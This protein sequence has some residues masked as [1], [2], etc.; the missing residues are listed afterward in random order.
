MSIDIHF[1]DKDWQRVERSW[2]DWWNGEIGRAMVIIEMTE[3]ILEEVCWSQFSRFGLDTPVEQILDNWEI[4]LN[5]TYFL[6][7]AVPRWWVNYGPGVMAAFLGANVSWTPDT[8]W[9]HPLENVTNLKDIVPIYNAENL[10]WKRIQEVTRAA[11]DRWKDSIS[12]G[13]TDIGGNLDILAS[14]RGTEKLLYDLIDSPEEV[15]RVVKE[16]T[17]LWLRYYEEL[18]RITAP[19]GRGFTCWEPI[20][21]AKRGYMLQS[22]FSYMISPSMFKRWVMPDIEAIC[23]HLEYGFY[24]LDGKGEIPHLEHLFTIE[25]LRG[26]QWQPGDG[27][28]LADAWLPLLKHIRDNNKLCQVFVNTQGAMTIQR[29]LGGKGFVFHIINE[30]LSPEQ[31]QS[32]LNVLQR[33]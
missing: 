24:H 26:I 4:I 6:G 8:T 16:I 3:P 17:Q 27:Q 1:T 20:L 33:I 23:N 31:A 29:E 9:F 10:W 28:P 7:D 15:D 14:L 12:I 2:Q 18:Y 19:T 21:S 5:H 11:V 25:R 22:D 30:D 32:F 13:M